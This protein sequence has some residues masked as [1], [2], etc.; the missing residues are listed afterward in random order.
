ME[1]SF[2]FGELSCSIKT[3]QNNIRLAW[4]ANSHHLYLFSLHFYDFGEGGF[5]NL[6]LKFSKIVRSSNVINLFLHFAVNPL[7]KASNMNF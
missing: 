3:F 1:A 4:L 5:A 2:L 7:P 6:T